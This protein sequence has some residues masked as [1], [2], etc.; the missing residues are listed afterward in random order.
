MK[1]T[2]LFLYPIKSL[3]GISLQESQISEMG[4]L[5]DRKF[6]IVKKVD[7]M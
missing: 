1:I 5:H 2:E 6:M 3:K 4:L 7:A